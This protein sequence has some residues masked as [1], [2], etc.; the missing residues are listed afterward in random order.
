MA[1]NLSSAG[2]TL[3][4][5]IMVILVMGIL[6]VVAAPRFA[7]HSMELSAAAKKFAM[8]IRYCQELNMIRQ[9]EDWR[10]GFAADQ[11]YLWRDDNHNEVKDAA[12][13]YA[14]DPVGRVDYQVFLRELRL[15][16]LTLN[17]SLSSLGFS[18]RGK[19]SYSGSAGDYHGIDF[20]LGRGGEQA[21]LHLES[22]TG[23]VF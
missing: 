11:Y 16:S 17:P 3:I 19:P 4:E 1:E 6:A 15:D 8:D 9:G 22:I 20:T 10:L 21:T 23:N 18:G 2:F 5:L 13:P 7:G 12:E 14:V